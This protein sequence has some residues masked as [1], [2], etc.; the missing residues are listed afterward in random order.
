MSTYYG[1]HTLYNNHA[2]KFT[3]WNVVHPT[4]LHSLKE[5]LEMKLIFV[6][7]IIH[8]YLTLNIE[9]NYQKPLS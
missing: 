4:P 8:D 1:I 2:D 5:R 7:I 3:A 6:I 9:Q